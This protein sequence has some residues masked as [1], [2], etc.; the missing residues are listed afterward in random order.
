MKMMNSIALRIGN[1]KLIRLWDR[2]AMEKI[3]AKKMMLLKLLK[4][5]W[6]NS[7]LFCCPNPVPF[8]MKI[9]TT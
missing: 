5:E 2:N 7:Q 9:G 1:A 8:A 3:V 4:R 6:L